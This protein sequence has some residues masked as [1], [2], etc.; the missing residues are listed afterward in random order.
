[1]EN[2]HNQRIE[3]LW[4]D[5]YKGCLSV[6]HNLFTN[7]ESA[8]ALDVNSDNNMYTLHFAFLPIIQRKLD[9][10]AASFNKHPV[11]TEHSKTPEQLFAMGVFDHFKCPPTG[12]DAIVL[13][14]LQEPVHNEEMEQ[15]PIPEILRMR[16]EVRV[17]EL[18]CTLGDTIT[19][20]LK[21]RINPL[22]D[23]EDNLGVDVYYKAMSEVAAHTT[24]EE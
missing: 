19:E 1:M 20:S 22:R 12:V 7:L 10:F 4:V 11:R 18:T 15:G 9:E 5:V 6:Y 17:P 14:T 23:C 13:P 24:A 8:G 21:R 3:R 2:L 16:S